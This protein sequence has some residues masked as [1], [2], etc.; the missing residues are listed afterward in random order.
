MMTLQNATTHEI[1][2]WTLPNCRGCK[3]LKTMLDSR[4]IRYTE[5]HMNDLQSGD[6][7]DPGAMTEMILRDGEAPMIRVDGEFIPH[8]GFMEMLPNDPRVAELPHDQA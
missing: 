5:K 8:S 4:G 1:E 2:V 3:E 6:E 7:P